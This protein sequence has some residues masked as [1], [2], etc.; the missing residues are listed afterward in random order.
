[1]TD[2]RSALVNNNLLAGLVVDAGLDPFLLH[3]APQLGH[4]VVKRRGDNSDD[5]DHPQGECLCCRQEGQ[6]ERDQSHSGPHQRGGASRG[7]DDIPTL[8]AHPRLQVELVEVPKVL[9]DLLESL[10]GAVFLDSGHDLAEVWGVFHRL[11]P[12]LDDILESPPCT[13]Y[14]RLGLYLTA[15]NQKQHLQAAAG[16]LP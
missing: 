9:G 2:A 6:Q 14:K 10:L 7:E 16:A 5:D 11:C 3:W 12:G 13:N 8:V 15:I 4:K 1:M